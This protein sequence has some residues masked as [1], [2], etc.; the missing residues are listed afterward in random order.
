VNPVDFLLA[1]DR[2]LE[3]PAG[4]ACCTDGSCHLCRAQAES[5]ARVDDVVHRRTITA[6][7]E[8]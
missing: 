5:D 3:R 1:L 8:A 7:K 6:T 4:E 2:Q